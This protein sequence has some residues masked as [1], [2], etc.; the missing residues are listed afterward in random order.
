MILC[1]NLDGSQSK[2]NFLLSIDVGVKH[3]QNMLKLL[4]NYKGLLNK[5]KL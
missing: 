5:V 2:H 3:T 4:R 1:T